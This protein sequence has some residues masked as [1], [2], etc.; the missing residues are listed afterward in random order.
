MLAVCDEVDFQ[1][2]FDEVDAAVV[3]EPKV[4][5]RFGDFISALAKSFWDVVVG[6]VL[7]VVLVVQ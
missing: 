5:A 3:S 1:V 7:L 6:D 2:S 4:S